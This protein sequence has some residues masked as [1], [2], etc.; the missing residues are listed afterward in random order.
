MRRRSQLTHVGLCHPRRVCEHF[1]R[2]EIVGRLGVT[3][4]RRSFGGRDPGKEKS[5]R[6]AHGHR[7]QR[8]ECATPR[9]AER[10]HLL[11]L[12]KEIG[13]RVEK[14]AKYESASR[15]DDGDD[16]RAEAID[17]VDDCANHTGIGDAQ[18]PV[19][20]D[21]REFV[22][23]LRRVVAE[24][25]AEEVVERLRLFGDAEDVANG[26]ASDEIARN[27]DQALNQRRL[28][29]RIEQRGKRRRK[30]C[31][32]VP[33]IAKLARRE[34]GNEE[35]RLGHAASLTVIGNGNAEC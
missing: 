14:C 7:V 17:G 10:D 35:D 24:F 16:V 13:P 9:H 6:L 29:R 26:R 23:E 19:P 31:P 34:T 20:S 33:P 3:D 8:F 4:D 5:R 11:E 32:P 1:G 2:K 18:P 28:F 25:S 15:M 21:R 30:N 27:R 22:A 12:R